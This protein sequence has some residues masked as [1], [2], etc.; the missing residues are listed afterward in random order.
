MFL[1]IALQNLTSPPVLFFVIGV[2]ASLARSDLAVPDQI[3]RLL[4]R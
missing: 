4:S 2:A 1:D 3:A